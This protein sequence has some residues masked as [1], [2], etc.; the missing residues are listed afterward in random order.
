[1]KQSNVE[2]VL[3]KLG[4]DDL[5]FKAKVDNCYIDFYSKKQ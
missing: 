1:M 2:Q 5:E 3:K 4:Y